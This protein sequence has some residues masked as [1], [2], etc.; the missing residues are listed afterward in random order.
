MGVLRIHRGVILWAGLA[1]N[2]GLALSKTVPFLL[3]RERYEWL[4][5]SLLIGVALI[6]SLVKPRHR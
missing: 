2:A 4:S 1:V 5:H 3:A 6:T